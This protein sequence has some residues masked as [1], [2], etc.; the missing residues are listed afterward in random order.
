MGWTDLDQHR[1]YW[2]LLANTVMKLQ[3]PLIAAQL[4]VFEDILS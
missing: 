1:K 3:F 4:V 2:R